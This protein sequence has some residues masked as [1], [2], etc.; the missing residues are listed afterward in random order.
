MST[1]TQNSPHLRFEKFRSETYSRALNLAFQLTGNRSE[2]EDLVQD[3]YV[4][5]WRKFDS[6]QDDRP[7]LNWI[8]RIVQRHNLDLRRRD[9]PIRRADSL[10]QRRSPGDEEL[11]EISVPNPA[12]NPLQDVMRSESIAAVRAA[13]DKLPEPYGQAIRLCDIEGFSYTEIAEM[14]GTTLGTVRSRIHRARHM[15]RSLLVDTVH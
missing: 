7:F 9:N 1:L 4:K 12:D 3:A 8:L 10:L 6:Y 11:V 15:L 2:A 13:L 5:A 14:Q